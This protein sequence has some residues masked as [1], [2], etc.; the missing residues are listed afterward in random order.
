MTETFHNLLLR[1]IK[2]HFGSVDKIPSELMAFISSVNTAYREYDTDREML[3]RSLELSSQEMLQTNAEL[4]AVFSA[5][6][7]ILFVIDENGIILDQKARSDEDVFPHTVKK[8]LG[9][10]IQDVPDRDAGETLQRALD[11]VK[12]DKTLVSSEYQLNLSDTPSFYESRFMPLIEN[13]YI[14]IVRN[15]TARKLAE[16]AL[17]KERDFVR[18]LVQ[19]SPAF[20]IAL[21]CDLRI[22]TINDAMLDATGFTAEEVVG[23]ERIEL[24]VPADAQNDIVERLQEIQKSAEPAVIEAPVL[25]KKRPDSEH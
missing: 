7:D 22:I 11:T 25:C 14:V 20:F 21:D 4:R 13:R 15:I 10:R 12:Q 6:P 18:T 19:T 2:R 23:K 9:R 1:Q 8:L 16:M 17:L 3:E 5:L 24:F